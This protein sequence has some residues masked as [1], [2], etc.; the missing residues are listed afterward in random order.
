MKRGKQREYDAC[1]IRE[2]AAAAIC[3]PRTVVRFL[4]GESVQGTSHMRISRAM[5]S[6]GI[7]A[8]RPARRAR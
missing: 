6:L 5:E 7:A 4:A 8:E 2:I 3:D 1:Q